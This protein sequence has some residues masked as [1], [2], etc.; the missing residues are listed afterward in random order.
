MK[1]AELEQDPIKLTEVLDV[2]ASLFCLQYLGENVG[3]TLAPADVITPNH[4]FWIFRRP[5]RHSY[6]V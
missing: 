5:P 2:E 6:A 4:D 1:P 3:I